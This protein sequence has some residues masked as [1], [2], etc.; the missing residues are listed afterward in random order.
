MGSTGWNYGP[1]YQRSPC[2]RGW[3]RLLSQ[4]VP[5]VD[6]N[7][8]QLAS[9]AVNCRVLVCL[10][11][12]CP[13]REDVFL[14]CWARISMTRK[15][16]CARRAMPGL[17][18]SAGAYWGVQQE[19]KLVVTAPPPF[20]TFQCPSSLSIR[21]LHEKKNNDKEQHERKQD[22]QPT[23]GRRP[24]TETKHQREVSPS[25]QGQSGD[26]VSHLFCCR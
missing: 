18:V 11:R 15:S 4:Q 21:R 2:R 17:L 1:G 5:E 7:R 3:G 13:S 12:R 6:S 25:G 24:A 10:R 22:D 8:A 16:V 9:D 23:K 20:P 14:M 19:Y 26:S